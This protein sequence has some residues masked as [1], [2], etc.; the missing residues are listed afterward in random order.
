[1]KPVKMGFIGTGGIAQAHLRAISDVDEI[2]VV[3]AA[4]IVLEN[5]QKTAQRWDIPHVYEDYREMVEAQ[6][7]AVADDLIYGRACSWPLK[8]ALAEASELTPI[9][10][11]RKRNALWRVDAP[12]RIH[13]ASGSNA[14]NR[15]NP[16]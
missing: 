14:L 3:A 6:L 16:A 9:I 4:D 11:A 2:E 5:A 13:Q 10:G 8:L 7:D 1:M 15:R 12:L